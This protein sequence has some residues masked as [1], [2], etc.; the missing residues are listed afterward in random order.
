M[1]PR[2]RHIRRTARWHHHRVGR[3]VRV[4][5]SQAV[6][7]DARTTFEIPVAPHPP[8]RAVVVVALL[9][10]VALSAL[11]HRA[12]KREGCSVG[13]PQRV[14]IV[15][16][17][18]GETTHVAVREFD[19]AVDLGARVAR[20]EAAVSSSVASR[21]R[22]AIGHLGSATHDLDGVMGR[23]WGRHRSA[24]R[25][26]IAATRSQRDPRER[27]PAEQARH[28]R[29]VRWSPPGVPGTQRSA[30]P[31]TGRRRSCARNRSVEDG[32]A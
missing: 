21:T 16:V 15:A 20:G 25:N 31:C 1:C 11:L 29:I 22:H 10:A 6:V 32:T 5:T 26:V 13:Q 28:C 19:L 24:R 12:G 3:R 18:A 14:A 27:A 17:V 4:V 23:G 9:R 2:L 8:V 30:V 7:P